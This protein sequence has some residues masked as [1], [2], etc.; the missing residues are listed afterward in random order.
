MQSL[1]VTATDGAL[2]HT[3]AFPFYVV[4][5]SGSLSQSTLTLARG[6]ISSLT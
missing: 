5:Y 2:S 4:D 3:A 6:A 1:S